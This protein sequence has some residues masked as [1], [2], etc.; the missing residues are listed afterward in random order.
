MVDVGDDRAMADALV[1]F[2]EDRS[3]ALAAGDA[4]REVASTRFDP[5]A[6]TAEVLDVYRELVPAKGT[7]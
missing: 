6:L 2:L 4:G 1:R 3:G 5:D 7:R